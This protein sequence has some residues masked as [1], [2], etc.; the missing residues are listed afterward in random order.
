MHDLGIFAIGHQRSRWLTARVAA[1][2]TNVANADTPGF[3]ARD[4]APFEATLSAVRSDVDRTQPGHLASEIRSDQKIRHCSKVGER[5]EA[6]RQRCQPGGRDGNARR[7]AS[8]AVVG[9]WCVGGVSQNAAVELQGVNMADDLKVAT[10]SS[11]A[12]LRVQSQRLRIVSENIANANATASTAGG[13]PYVRK[14]ISFKEAIDRVSGAST[15]QVN[16]IG[17]DRTPFRIEQN[18]GHP[19]ADSSGNVKLPNVNPLIELSDMREAHRSYEANLQVIKQAREMLTELL[20]L[21]K[22][23]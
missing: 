21:M 18:P 15:I 1:V 14:T 20:E 7:S 8:S 11:A 23:R 3:K 6:L 12:A 13:L 19:A 10:M 16:S 17:T 5:A 22:S 4:V 9:G 2:A